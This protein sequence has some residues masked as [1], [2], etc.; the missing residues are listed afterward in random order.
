VP[1]ECRGQ[2]GAL[3]PLEAEEQREDPGE[4]DP[5]DQWGLPVHQVQSGPVAHLDLPDSPDP[6]GLWGRLVLSGTR[7]LSDQLEHLDPWGTVALRG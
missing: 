7:G 3:V 6:L 2:R 1:R 4:L 5:Q